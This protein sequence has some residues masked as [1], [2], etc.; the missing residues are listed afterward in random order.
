MNRLKNIIFILI[1]TFCCGIVK[2]AAAFEQ[3]KTYTVADG[4]VGPIVPVIFQD[5]RGVLWFGSDR[6]GISRFDG[7]TFVPYSGDSE[8]LRG[9]TKNIVEDKWGHI[10]FLSKHPSEGRGWCY[11]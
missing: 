7:N 1:F 9:R 11:Q 6:S 8:V 4:L 10:W 3:M 5:S 2:F